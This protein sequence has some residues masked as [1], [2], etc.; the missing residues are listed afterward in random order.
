MKNVYLTMLF[1]AFVSCSE[2]SKDEEHVSWDK[3]E[4]TSKS[5]EIQVVAVEYGPDEFG[6]QIL[7]NGKL[8]ID[9]QHIPAVQGLKRFKSREEAQRLGNHVSG[10]IEKG[11]MPPTVSIS[12]LDSLYISY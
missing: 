3:V 4:M 6:Y 1:F 10:M 7:Q 2:T 12:D 9:Q 11:I 5:N 8:L